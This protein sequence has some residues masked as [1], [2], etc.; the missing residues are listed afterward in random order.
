MLCHAMYPEVR[1]GA[2]C[3]GQG[4]KS[5]PPCGRIISHGFAENQTSLGRLYWTLKAW[6]NSGCGLS[7]D[8]LV[9]L[10]WRAFEWF[11]EDSPPAETSSALCA[12]RF[13]LEVTLICRAVPCRF[14]WF[15]RGVIFTFLWMKNI[16]VHQGFSRRSQQGSHVAVLP[17]MFPHHWNF[18]PVLQRGQ[19]RCWVCGTV[20]YLQGS[21]LPLHHLTA[22][23]WLCC[24]CELQSRNLLPKTILVFCKENRSAFFI[25]SAQRTS[26]GWLL[27]EIKWLLKKK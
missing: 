5:S 3:T 8:Q 18:S 23:A 27:Y 14:L 11:R 4:E 16:S 17:S 6:L 12:S 9:A 13:L 22:E 15:S 26:V 7:F 2:G 10:I 20:G 19:A 25:E 21:T 24:L 1:D